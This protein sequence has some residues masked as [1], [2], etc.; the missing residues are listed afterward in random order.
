MLGLL[1]QAHW[2]AGR[3]DQALALCEEA[4]VSG[5]RSDVHFFDAEVHR[6]K[7]ACLLSRHNVAAAETSFEL[8][9]VVAR[10]QG[11]RMLELRG[12][13][14]LASLRRSQG[15]GSA[16]CELLSGAIGSLDRTEMAPDLQEAS[17]LL[18]EWSDR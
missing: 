14:A 1:A 4:L 17:R 5:A 16:A 12:A 18:H 15:Q 8:A 2:G 11:A 9:V 6:L 3:F 13:I 7:G 10:D